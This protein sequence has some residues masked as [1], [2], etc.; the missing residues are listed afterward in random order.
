MAR[1]GWLVLLVITLFG[2]APARAE[3]LQQVA[4]ASYRQRVF[5]YAGV[6]STSDRTQLRGQLLAMEKR[7]VAQGAVIVLHRVE[8]VT[9]E[10]FAREIGNRWAL[11]ERGKNDGF[12]IVVALEQRKWRLETGK[13]LRA[14]IPDAAAAELMRESVVP[15]FRQKQYAR[16]LATALSAIDRKA[17]SRA[18]APIEAASYS[19]GSTSAS[20][21]AYLSPSYSG[22]G[23][24][25]LLGMLAAAFGVI[26]F[27]CLLASVALSNGRS[28]GVTGVPRIRPHHPHHDQHQDHSWMHTSMGSSSYSPPPVDTSPPP[29]N[30][31]EGGGGGSMDGGGG[32]SGSW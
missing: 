1:L 17:S 6:L 19:L 9:I 23:E 22:S 18:A 25:D 3:T 26:V 4:A 16:G 12:V 24:F 13:G 21:P 11:G 10:R 20:A 31:G 5:D 32:A 30:G 28:V 29:S 8:G 14:R 7:H 27:I 2:A 15:H